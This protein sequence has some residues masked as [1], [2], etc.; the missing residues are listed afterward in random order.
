[1]TDGEWAW[2]K[3]RRDLIGLNYFDSKVR[4]FLLEEVFEM[5]QAKKHWR[6]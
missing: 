3:K 4:A 5:R 1:M 2:D 6:K